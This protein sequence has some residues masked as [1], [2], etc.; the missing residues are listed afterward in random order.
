M[1][2]RSWYNGYSAKER[3][4][5]YTELKRELA[6]NDMSRASGPCALCGDPGVDPAV[7]AYQR[8]IGAEWFANLRMDKASLTD[9]SARKR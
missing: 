1:T 4:A 7:S 2:I 5:K 3:V 8:V 6:G 9:P